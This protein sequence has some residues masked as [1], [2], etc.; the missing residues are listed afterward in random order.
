MEQIDAALQAVEE[1][2]KGEDTGKRFSF[3]KDRPGL[4]ICRTHTWLPAPQQRFPQLRREAAGTP[5]LYAEMIRKN[6]ILRRSGLSRLI[7]SALD[8]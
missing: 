8:V 5:G 1:I 2:G 7:P 4:R 6:Q 3:T